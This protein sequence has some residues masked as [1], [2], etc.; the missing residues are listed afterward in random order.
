MMEHQEADALRW[1]LEDEHGKW[2]YDANRTNGMYPPTEHHAQF[3]SRLSTV[4]EE[5]YA[6]ETYLRLEDLAVN[7]QGGGA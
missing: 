2:W 4:D 6:Y 3:M 7:P 5:G 1:F